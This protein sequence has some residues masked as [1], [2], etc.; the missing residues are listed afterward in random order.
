MRNGTMQTGE[1]PRGICLA[2]GATAAWGHD[3]RPIVTIDWENKVFR[4]DQETWQE[5]PGEW[6]EDKDIVWEAE[7][8]R[9]V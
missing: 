5:F 3:T 6:Y 1:A 8:G 2:I 4:R 7:A 9:A